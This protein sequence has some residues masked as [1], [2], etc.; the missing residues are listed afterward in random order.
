M[1]NSTEAQEYESDF[2]PTER[3]DGN[4]NQPIEGA[5]GSGGVSQEINSLYSS[6]TQTRLEASKLLP[7]QRN[8]VLRKLQ[9]ISGSHEAKLQHDA[10]LNGWSEIK[11]YDR[12]TAAFVKSE[13]FLMFNGK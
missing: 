13:L 11:P 1:E 9:S 7:E 2:V 10:I 12:A 6:D 8:D 4:N 5:F 3:T